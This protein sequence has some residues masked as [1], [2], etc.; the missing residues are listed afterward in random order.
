MFRAGMDPVKKAIFMSFFSAE[1]MAAAA[2][3]NPLPPDPKP[4]AAADPLPLDPNQEGWNSDDSARTLTPL[5]CDPDADL[6]PCQVKPDP[7]PSIVKS[8]SSPV[9][10]SFKRKR[11]AARRKTL[12]PH[13]R[14]MFGHPEPEPESESCAEESESAEDEQPTPAIATPAIAPPAPE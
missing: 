12:V 5:L 10:R 9:P 4:A 13:L 11:T 6:E 8:S 2:A 7:E 14:I 1:S 3:A